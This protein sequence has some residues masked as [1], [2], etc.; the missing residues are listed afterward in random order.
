[1]IPLRVADL[2]TS[3]HF[4]KNGLKFPKMETSPDITIFN[5]R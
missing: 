4:Y 1:M 5:T 2:E 3:I